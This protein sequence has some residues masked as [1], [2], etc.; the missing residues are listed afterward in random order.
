MRYDQ[1]DREAVQLV[2]QNQDYA[3]Y[4][5][6]GF[7]D[8]DLLYES[9]DSYEDILTESNDFYADMT[10]SNSNFYDEE[11]LEISK[12]YIDVDKLQSESS[13]VF[14]PDNQSEVTPA[15]TVKA[16]DPEP[17]GIADRPAAGIVDDLDSKSSAGNDRTGVDVGFLQQELKMPLLLGL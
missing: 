11:P 12:E 13:P 15:G 16:S 17:S 3:L 1:G 7:N 6:F 8:A 5:S 2:D 14:V 10:T 9:D 4:S